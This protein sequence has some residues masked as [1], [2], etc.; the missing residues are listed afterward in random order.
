MFPVW[1]EH[2]GRALDKA[3][4]MFEI[5][6]KETALFV[7]KDTIPDAAKMYIVVK[8]TEGIFQGTQAVNN[9]MPIEAA[10]KLLGHANVSTT[11]IYAKVSKDIIHAQHTRYVI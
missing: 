1:Y 9:G 2:I 7:V 10:S 8:K 11:M 3:A 4:N 5:Q 6:K